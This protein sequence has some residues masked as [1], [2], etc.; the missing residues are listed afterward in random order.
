MNRV[1]DLEKM[2]ME[3]KSWRDKIRDNMIQLKL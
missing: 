1:D 2:Q 3:D